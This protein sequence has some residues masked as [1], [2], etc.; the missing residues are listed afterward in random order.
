MRNA[1]LDVRTHDACERREKKD[2]LHFVNVTMPD[3]GNVLLPCASLEWMDRAFFS[4][5]LSILKMMTLINSGDVI[6][7][8]SLVSH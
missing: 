7:L 4:V 1:S 6:I 3:R 2:A 8:T 5:E